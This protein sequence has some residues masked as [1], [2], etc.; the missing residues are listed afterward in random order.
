MPARILNLQAKQRENYPWAFISVS[1]FTAATC[2][3]KEK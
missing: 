1:R 2:A 3:E